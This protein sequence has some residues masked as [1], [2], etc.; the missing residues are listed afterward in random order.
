MYT[1]RDTADRNEPP[2]ARY[3]VHFPDNR[4]SPRGRRQNHGSV[5]RPYR[6]DDGQSRAA[7]NNVV[8]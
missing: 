4:N 3:V 5:G 6:T 1:P 8:R 7:D 2:D